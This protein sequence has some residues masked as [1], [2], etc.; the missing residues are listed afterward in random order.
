M[1]LKQ[2]LIGLICV[3]STATALAA[4]F[5]APMET[6]R[7]Q[8]D[9]SVFACK[10]Y[11]PVALYGEAVFLRPAGE[12][13]RF[14]LQESNRQLGAGEVQVHTHSPLWQSLHHS[15]HLDT[16]ST[17]DSEQPLALDW[18]QSQRLISQLQAGQQLSFSHTSWY[19][20]HES[21]EVMLAPIRFRAAFAEYQTCLQ[22]LLPVNYAQIHRSTVSF[23]TAG[24]EFNDDQ[25]ELMDNLVRYVLA[26]SYVTGLMIDGHTDGQGLRADNLELSKRRAESVYQYIIERGVPEQLV[27]LRWHGERYPIASNRTPEG[28]A[29]NRRVTIRVDRFEPDPA[30]MAARSGSD[31]P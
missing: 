2:F 17:T 27:T 6:T 10:L 7:W 18:Q 23:A 11:Q 13:Q 5:T 22:N 19:D 8:V 20:S 24:D 3:G 4:T 31:Q 30:Q 21:V 9:A 16:F 15:R 28:R 25:R 1:Q 14:Y 26:D 12:T 29:E